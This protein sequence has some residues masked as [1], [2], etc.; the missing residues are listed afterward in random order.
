MEMIDMYE[1]EWKRAELIA[2]K[3]VGIAAEIE[4][5]ICCIKL[6][7]NLCT[8][9]IRFNSVSPRDHYVITY[10]AAVHVSCVCKCVELVCDSDFRIHF[11]T[12]F[13]SLFIL[14]LCCLLYTFAQ[15]CI[16]HAQYASICF[17][18]V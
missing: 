8:C 14:L 2:S 12:L 11:T 10:Y 1:T 18:N 7:H 13:F 15:T 4:N 5:R 17:C 3:T 16:I 6:F 9:I